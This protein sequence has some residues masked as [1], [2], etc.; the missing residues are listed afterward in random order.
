[1]DK[2]YGNVHKIGSEHFTDEDI[3]M[4]KSILKNYDLDDPKSSKEAKNTIKNALHVVYDNTVDDILGAY[5]FGRLGSSVNKSK[6][7]ENLKE[8]SN[9]ITMK[10][11]HG[12][13]TNL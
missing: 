5:V 13:I 11:S 2:L 3:R 7:P 8:I 12:Y 10:M 1:M 4:I 6:R 9:K